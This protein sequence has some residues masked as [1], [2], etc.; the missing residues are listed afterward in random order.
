MEFKPTL[1]SDTLNETIL[2]PKNLISIIVSSS[3]EKVDVSY[4]YNDL[5][6]RNT[7]ENFFEHPLYSP[8]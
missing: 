6:L 2:V 3:V 4:F 5:F 8:Y 1:T 7:I